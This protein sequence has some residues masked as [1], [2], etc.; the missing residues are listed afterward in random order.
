MPMKKIL[1][2]DDNPKDLIS[3][4]AILSNSIEEYKVLTTENGNNGID[5]A[6]K[7]SPDIIIIDVKLPDVDGFEVCQILKKDASTSH[8]PIIIISAYGTNTNNRLNSL[9]AGAESF[10]SKPIDAE[11]LLGQLKVLFRLKDIEDNLKKERN[12]FEK[13]AQLKTN[14]LKDVNNYLNLQIKR[15]P[16]G[17]ISWDPNLKIR[18]WNPAATKIFGYSAKESIGKS[19]LN[20]ILAP[21][22]KKPIKDIWKRLMNGDKSA[23]SINKNLTKSGKTIICEWTNTPLTN[24]FGE[25]IGVLSMVKDITAQHFQN[26]LENAIT[27]LN[28]SLLSA[29]GKDFLTQFVHQLTSTLEAELTFIGLLNKDKRGITTI[30][31]CKNGTISNNF[32]YL[33]KNSPCEKVI[34]NMICSY[35]SNVTALFPYD[36][37]LK[38]FNVQGYVGVP[39]CDNHGNVIGLVVALFQNII[40]EVGFC[41]SIIQIFAPRAAAELERIKFEK[42]VHDS[43]KQFRRTV[44]EFPYPL[45]ITKG[46]KYVYLNRKFTSVFGYTLNDIPTTND[47]FRMAY[48]DNEYRELVR[49]SWNQAVEVA[50]EN[51]TEIKTQ[52]WKLFTKEGIEKTCEHNMVPLGEESLIV[53]N[54]ITKRKRAELIQIILYQISNAANTSNDLTEFLGLIR[55]HLANVLDTTNFYVA[56]IDDESNLLYTP[57]EVDEK[58][59]IKSWPADKSLTGYII[60]NI[61]PLFI[62]KEEILQMHRSG[63]IDLIGTPP[64][65]WVGVPLILDDKVLGAFV[66]QSYTNPNAYDKKDVNL[67]QFISHQISISIQRIRHGEA[68]ES[69]L[70]KAIESDR[71]KSVFLSTMSHELRTPL[72]AI[73]GFSELIDSTTDQQDVL[74]FAKTIFNSGTLLLELVEGLFDITLIEAG[75]IKVDKK[76]HNLKFIIDDVVGLIKAEQVKTDK[77]NLS[78]EIGIYPFNREMELFTDNQKLKQILL[79]LL[80]NALKFT[81]FGSIRL[82]VSKEMIAQNSFIKF[83][84]SDTGIGIPKDKFKIIFDIFRQADDTHTRKYGGAG[85]G[86]SVTQKLTSLLGGKID[87][88]SEVG[89]GTTFSVLIPMITV[90]EKQELFSLDKDNLEIVFPQK[91]ILIVED[92]PSSM[93]LLKVHLRKLGVKILYANNGK[94]AIELFGKNKQHIDL[95]LMDINMPVM[96]GFDATLAIKKN[97]PFVPIIAQT[98]YAIAGDRE[99]AIA[100]GCDDYISKPINGIELLKLIKKYL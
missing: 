82:D 53:L 75:E 29:L 33:L 54:D 66:V 24:D 81:H 88:E 49:T 99:R 20:L 38:D 35:D 31:V 60:K 25:V 83:K 2:V 77:K 3:Y 65:V 41:E 55:H 57:F 32:T 17:L 26:K 63:E 4:T 80:K 100:S 95:V 62:T 19:P 42:A 7:E 51:G 22:L 79:N 76:F 72:N 37:K 68:L 9:N 64:E 58:D 14:K 16:I 48:P 84:V 94:E 97:Y 59:Q 91:S 40:S 86:L 87:V 71:L 56:F 6:R 70:E 93:N 1:I 10:L 8:I 18:S 28:K 90:D 12:K 78:F 43:E 27:S 69:A 50:I 89:K 46:N 44:E 47:W 13:I 96:N 92:D 11:E 45:A 15:M 98:A 73:I 5:I 39:L 85:I 74:R 61:K 34:N 36:E 30:S 21:E 23:H 52:E 67:L